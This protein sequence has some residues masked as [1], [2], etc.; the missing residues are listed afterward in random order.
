MI[1]HSL[2]I[3]G[4]S[5]SCHWCGSSPLLCRRVTMTVSECPLSTFPNASRGGIFVLR[6]IDLI[7]RMFYIHNFVNK[8][9]PIIA[10]VCHSILIRTWRLRKK[11]SLRPKWKFSLILM[12]RKFKSLLLIKCLTIFRKLIPKP[13]CWNLN[14]FLFTLTAVTLKMVIVLC[15]CSLKTIVL[16]DIQK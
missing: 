6:S 16:F 10:S 14:P 2:S 7:Q 13:L 4:P 5:T 3:W 8:I 15:Q 12:K 1:Y 11:T 9:L